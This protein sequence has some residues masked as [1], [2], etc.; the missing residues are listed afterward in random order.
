MFTTKALLSSTTI[1]GGGVDWLYKCSASYDQ[2][3]RKDL[4]YI[5]F[6]TANI[7]LIL[8]GTL[9]SLFKLK[10]AIIKK[11]CKYGKKHKQYCWGFRNS[12]TQVTISIVAVVYSALRCGEAAS[13][14]FYCQCILYIYYK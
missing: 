14:F 5:R 3:S 1:E 11:D 8:A 4:I 12:S 9:R 2:V 13:L 7:N 6:H 10:W